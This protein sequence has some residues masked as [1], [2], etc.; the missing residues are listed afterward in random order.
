MRGL[1]SNSLDK[2]AQNYQNEAQ[3]L[4]PAN[5][6]IHYNPFVKRQFGPK[7]GETSPGRGEVSSAGEEKNM[8]LL[9]KPQT[10]VYQTGTLQGSTF[11]VKNLCQD[12][13]IEKALK[14]L[15]CQT[16]READI[17]LIVS[18][19]GGESEGYRLEIAESKITLV[20]ESAA[21]VFY[22]IQTLRQLLD[23]GEV[24]CLTITDE[25]GFDYRGFYHDVTRGKIPT[26]DTLKELIDQ[27][28]YY[29]MNSL[30]LY[31][32]HTFPFRE[33]G[34]Y[35]EKNGYL[36]PEEIVELDDYCYENFIEF[37]PSI[38][39]FGHLYELLQ[40]ENYRELQELENFEEDQL[41][42]Y[43]RMAHHTID[44]TNERSIEIIKSMIDQYI[45]LFRTDKFNIC[46]DETFDLKKGKHKEQDT[47]KLYIDFVKKIID[48]LQSKGKKVM[49][50]ADIL[51]QHP[52]TMQE[53][54]KGVEYL[55]WAYSAEP[56]EEPFRKFGEMKCTQ[57]VCPGTSSWSRLVEG[58]DVGS[59][60]ILKLGDYGYKYH[61]KGMLNTN[62][63]D[64]GNPC[65]IELA[66]HGLV[67]GA[68]KSWNA[69]TEKDAYFTESINY[70]LYKNDAAVDCL[71]VLDQLHKKLSWNMLAKVYSNCIYEKKF[72]LKFPALEDVLNTQ[73][74]GSNILQTLQSQIWERDE[75]RQ[76]IMLAAEGLI[77]MAELYA[78]FA[79]YKIDKCAN[80]EQ[81]LKKYRVKWL[82]KNKESELFR[83]EE[84]FT[85]LSR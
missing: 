58:I 48:Y 73:Q 2:K 4:F 23:N 65:S 50:W 81:W 55:N 43:Q 41:Y 36:T 24:H 25:P 47:G 1:D 72:E 29:K 75:Y 32:E 64:Y 42:W 14:K 21:G 39:T 85:V 28:A 74:V 22:G 82:E 62:W 34:A 15:P 63:G 19:K 18:E 45:P 61:A 12:T 84:M 52:E 46:C 59:K 16:N 5:I 3:K 30:Q 66:M 79:G 17:E 67:L 7:H 37:I 70:L 13:R 53:L 10:I 27:M 60:N 49:M 40:Q 9:P 71:S 69:D 8:Y 76:E 38:A 35:A 6:I 31:V 11:C 78:K 20:G 68:A 44:P 51:L 80:T 56:D 57:I 26:V 33:F 83:I 77:V 54:P